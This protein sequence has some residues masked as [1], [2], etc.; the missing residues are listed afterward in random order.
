[1][2]NQGTKKA[3]LADLDAL[4]KKKRELNYTIHRQDPLFQIFERRLYEFEYDT[5]DAFIDGVV[6]EYVEQLAS[7][8]STLLLTTHQDLIREAV[9]DEVSDML[10]RRIYGCLRVEGKVEP[11]DLSDDLPAETKTP[12]DSEALKRRLLKIASK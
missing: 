7:E 5:R 1:M 11:L 8:E 4:R 10:V 12:V 6:V 2:G 3:R 9:A